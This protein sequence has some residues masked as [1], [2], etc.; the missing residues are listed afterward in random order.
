M[1]M[2]IILL[3]FFK[4]SLNPYFYPYAIN[5]SERFYPL[6]TYLNFEAKDVGIEGFSFSFSGNHFYSDTLSE[7]R[8]FGLTASYSNSNYFINFGR[9][10][11][12]QGASSFI[13]GMRAGLNLEKLSISFYGGKKAFLPFK[14]DDVFSEK[15]PY[16]YGALLKFLF[17]PFNFSFYFNR[18]TDDLI[19]DANFAGISFKFEKFLKPFLSIGYSFKDNE[20]ERVETGLSYVCKGKFYTNLRYYFEKRPFKYL[21]YLNE[22][23]PKKERHRFLLSVHLR[24]IKFITPSFYYRFT[25]YEKKANYFYLNLRR[26]FLSFGIGLGN[27]EDRTQ[28]LYFADL[29]YPYRGFVFNISY[30]TFDD[31]EYNYYLNSFRAGVEYK[32]IKYMT[33]I[34]EIRFF[35]NPD[36]ESDVRG[37]FGVKFTYGG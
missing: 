10:F 21:Y 9:L 4:F 18:E 27:I 23:L 15:N 29:Y 12:Y 6:Y 33:F 25:Y 3:S 30:K 24:K 17:E 8:I 31:S 36:Y 7:F 13:D 22:I 1:N 34:S 28:V 37:F 11:V 19:K 35:A 5:D 14:S 20:I 32:G 26:K 16:I 2:I